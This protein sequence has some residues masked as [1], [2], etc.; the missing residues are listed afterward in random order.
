KRHCRPADIGDD[1]TLIAL[2]GRLIEAR[3]LTALDDPTEGVELAHDT[4][5]EAWPS[6]QGWVAKYGTNLVVRD[7]VERLRAAGAPRLEGWFARARARPTGRG[8][9]AARRGA[10]QAH[11]AL[12]PGTRG[13]PQ[14]RGEHRRRARGCLHQGRRLRDSHCPLSR[15]P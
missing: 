3:L 8:A 11:P 5:I 15:G 13:F 6:L 2:R 1:A 7:D 14:P 12:E 4:L 10:S 9:R